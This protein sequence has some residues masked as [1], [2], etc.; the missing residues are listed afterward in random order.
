MAFFEKPLRF[1][2]LLALAEED[3]VASQL[4]DGALSNAA[5]QIRDIY[6][7]ARPSTVA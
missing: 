6:A 7:A 4:D 2:G 5:R 1:R 3:G